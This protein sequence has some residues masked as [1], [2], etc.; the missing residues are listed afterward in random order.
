MRKIGLNNEYDIHLWAYPSISNFVFSIERLIETAS[1]ESVLKGTLANA[2]NASIIDLQNFL[3]VNSVDESKAAL[4]RWLLKSKHFNN[5]TLA[6]LKNE[7]INTLKVDNHLRHTEENKC[8]KAGKED[9][10][11]EELLEL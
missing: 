11:Q 5:E 6:F 1:K 3:T 7:I 9:N 4:E 2:L 8:R 10:M